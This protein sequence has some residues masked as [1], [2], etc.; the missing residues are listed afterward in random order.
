VNGGLTRSAHEGC[1]RMPVSNV[2]VILG[3]LINLLKIEYPFDKFRNLWTV[4]GFRPK[5]DAN[6]VRF[7]INMVHS[8]QLLLIL[9]GVRMRRG[10]KHIEA[11]KQRSDR[12]CVV[13]EVVLQRECRGNSTLQ[14]MGKVEIDP[15]TWL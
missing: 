10:L 13:R 8:L 7:L 4:V 9:D 11:V 15:I 5:P 12:S 6:V 3:P 2:P 1:E 14:Q